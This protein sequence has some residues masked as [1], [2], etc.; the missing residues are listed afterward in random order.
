MAKKRTGNA[1]SYCAGEK[2]RNRVRV[3]PEPTGILMLEWYQREPDGRRRRERVSLKHRD[4]ERA[5]RQADK[6]AVTLGE[7]VPWEPRPVTLRE[8]FDRDRKSVV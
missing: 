6:F 2:G 1:W 7:M 5:K 8:L 3:Y 4:T